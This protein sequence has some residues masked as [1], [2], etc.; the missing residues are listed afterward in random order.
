MLLGYNT[1]GL[2]HHHPRD[3]VELLT[4]IGYRSVAI[5]LDHGLVNPYSAAFTRQLVEMR[6][7]LEK[8]GMRSVVET[9]AR[10]LLNPH[11]KHEP[12]LI[13]ADPEGRAKRVWFLERAV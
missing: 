4:H 13:C 10:F 7:L 12:T 8:H 1:N 9:G 5:T 11:V 6:G 3:A 2:A